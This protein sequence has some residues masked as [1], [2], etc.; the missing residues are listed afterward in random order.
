MTHQIKQNVYLTKTNE[1]LYKI[2]DLLS[3]EEIR[4]TADLVIAGEYYTDIWNFT[5]ENHGKN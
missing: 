5:G 1:L 4:K 3:T 2:G